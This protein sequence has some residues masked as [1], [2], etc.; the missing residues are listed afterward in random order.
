M[1]DAHY[2]HLEV[3]RRGGALEAGAQGG[4]VWC[5]VNALTL[6]TLRPRPRAPARR[7]DGPTA[8]RIGP[9]YAACVL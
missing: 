7:L 9:D 5:V 4:R 8:G 3:R 2:S 1:G 6:S